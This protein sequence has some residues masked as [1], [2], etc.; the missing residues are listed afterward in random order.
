[1]KNND[2]KNKILVIEDGLTGRKTRLS[3]IYRSV[4]SEAE[5]EQLVQKNKKQN[6]MLALLV[7][8]I[9]LVA[10]LS[11]IPGAKESGAAVLDLL[12]PA[13]D[14]SPKTIEAEVSAEYEGYSIKERAS[15]R[16]LP[17]EPNPEETVLLITDLKR[18]LPDL[19][20][21]AN[22]SLDAVTED[23]YLPKM[24]PVTGAELSWRSSDERIISNYGKV[25]L[26]GAENGTAV[27]MSVYIRLASEYE[28]FHVGVVTGSGVTDE[29]ADAA[30]R[31]RVSEAIK[32][33]SNTNDGDAVLL[34]EETGDGVKL[35]WSP[36]KENNSIL[37]IFICGIMAFICFT[38]RYKSA[39]KTIEKA[40][41]DMERDYPDF[42][43]KLGLLLG[44][45]LVITSAIT[46]ITE[47]YLQTRDIYG[48]R[49]LFEEIAAAQDRMR[50]SGT[51]LV[52]E[53]SEIAR[54]SDLRE[55]MRFSSTLSDNI[56]KGSKL[57]D[58]LRIESE[59]LWESRK[60]RAEKEGRVAE[61]KLIFPMV[62]Q[63]F[64]VIAI[65]VM[66]AAFEMG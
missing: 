21:G 40:R 57:A 20:L 34:P 43:Q 44:A 3:E 8:L 1:M 14:D 63:I 10:I 42:V 41:S 52:F 37:I 58:K 26:I 15:I 62:L 36:Y 35:E 39:T 66:P 50:A 28:T 11:L 33:A 30:L 17:K 13:A 53:F 48:K 6:R 54:R 23:L 18:R 61:T 55:I 31:G 7:L 32:E 60:K 45:G 5:T 51:S 2:N 46:R 59:L 16:V 38:Q 29:R 9:M 22:A 24:D 65:T 27:A 25:N 19:I 56:D 64:V 4:F 47:D 49:R 12:R